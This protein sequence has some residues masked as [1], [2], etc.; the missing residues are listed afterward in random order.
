[1]REDS[2]RF[3]IDRSIEHLE[4]S[5]Q[6]ENAIDEAARIAGISRRHFNRI[7]QEIFGDTTGRH[8]RARRLSNAAKTL[9]SSK[10]S[11][12]HIAFDEGFNSH[13]AFTRAFSLYFG[14]SPTEYRK[15]GTVFVH[16]DKVPITRHYLNHLLRKQVSVAPR[17]ADVEERRLYGRSI[18]IRRKHRFHTIKMSMEL[19]MQKSHFRSILQDRIYMTMEPTDKKS[20]Y[21]LGDNDYIDVFMGFLCREPEDAQASVILPKR[22]Y[23]VF[24]HLC[25]L[26]NMQ[27]SYDYIYKTWIRKT[28]LNVRKNQ[29]IQSAADSIYMHP[30]STR[31]EM[32]I[33]IL[34]VSRP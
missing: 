1:M 28:E 8:I 33:P 22:R 19:A 14:I 2:A 9:I 15:I 25:G 20:F 5:I 34:S 18:T 24:N 26:Q 10:L 4:A 7:F 32:E 13:Q 30:L 3:R 6:E 16:A 11:V 29:I 23:A 31:I 17:L 12:T 21:E 27:L